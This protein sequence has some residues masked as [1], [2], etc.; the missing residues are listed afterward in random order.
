[1]PIFRPSA[2]RTNVFVTQL[3]PYGVLESERA[4]ERVAAA[5]NSVFGNHAAAGWGTS[6]A[7]RGRVW[8]QWTA[9]SSLAGASRLTDAQIEDG[10]RRAVRSA[11]AQIGGGKRLLFP[12]E[13]A[14]SGATPTPPPAAPPAPASAG[15][16]T[17]ATPET[18]TR[19]PARRRRSATPPASAAEAEFIAEGGESASSALP[20]WVVPVAVIGG[21]TVVGAIGILIWANRSPAK[22]SANRRRRRRRRRLK[23]NTHRSIKL[24]RI[25]GDTW[26]VRSSDAAVQR[27]L[28][29]MVGAG[30]S[31][32]APG[33]ETTEQWM[34]DRPHRDMIWNAL[35]SR[36][37]DERAAFAHLGAS[38][39]G[40]VPWAEQR[41]YNFFSPEHD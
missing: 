7:T 25:E 19:R 27:L 29:S 31:L 35:R 41:V 4:P 18:S 14:P 6:E 20:D 28:T 9:F 24:D 12:G 36:L 17:P 15:T 3:R 37:K 26:V 32:S 1:M 5:L 38:H 33:G 30:R 23:S 16:P 39:G 11:E 10:L 34:L 40:L 13:A 8:V 2:T 22:V 21:V